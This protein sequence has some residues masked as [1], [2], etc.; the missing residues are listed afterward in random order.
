MSI[1]TPF[2]NGL[3]ISVQRKEFSNL[4]SACGTVK[5][6]THLAVGVSGGADS[7]ALCILSNEWGR[8]N[9][10]SVTALVVDHGL[11]QNSS[12]EAIKVSSWLKQLKINFD[13]LT[14]KKTNQ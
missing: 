13:I 10:V 2:T 14:I 7:M 12:L 3:T 5:N 11:R 9:G 8:L 4:I 1:E 6:S